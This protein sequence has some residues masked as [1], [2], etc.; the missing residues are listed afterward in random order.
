MGPKKEKPVLKV[1]PG[2]YL[3]VPSLLLRRKFTATHWHDNVEQAE[4]SSTTLLNLEQ[5]GWQ[6][7]GKCSSVGGV[8]LRKVLSWST[9][10][11]CVWGV[12][13]R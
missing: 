10:L 6:E 3:S 4:E 13:S 8:M 2:S 1:Q 7:S 12:N 11:C 5:S 9:E